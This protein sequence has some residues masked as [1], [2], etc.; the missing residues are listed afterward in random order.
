MGAI[1]AARSLPAK[2][3][4]RLQFVSRD[5]T[6]MFDYF[7]TPVSSCYYPLLDAGEILARSLVK[8]VEG[9][10][11]ATLQTVER[12]QLIVRPH[13]TIGETL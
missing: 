2:D 1:S 7:D 10:G 4:K 12:T 8:A 11:I 6:N 3:F 9:A 5:G 13:R